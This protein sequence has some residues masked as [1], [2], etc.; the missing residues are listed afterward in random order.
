MSIETEISL[1]VTIVLGIGAMCQSW[2]YNRDTDKVSKDI[3]YMLVEQFRLL[4]EIKGNI[5]ILS[6]NPKT[7]RLSKDEIALHKLC[8]F[9]KKDVP[10]IMDK[11]E[12]L[13]IKRRFINNIGEFLESEDIN[14]KHNF[15]GE[16]ASDGQVNIEELY[17]ILLEYNV[18]LSIIK[19]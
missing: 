18:L 8:K 1:C 14:C 6:K 15:I 7:I 16:A 10:K 11:I 2:R 4:N 9:N 13:S 17:A 5:Q 12:H 19:H 3:K